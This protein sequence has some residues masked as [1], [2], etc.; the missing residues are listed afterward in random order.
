MDDDVECQIE[1]REIISDEGHESVV[2]DSLDV[3][4]SQVIQEFLSPN[5]FQGASSS[6]VPFFTLNGS[7]YFI[8]EVQE[9]DKPVV[10]TVF[11][12][13]DEAL[14]MYQ[15]YAQKARFSVRKY[16]AKRKSN[17]DLSHRL[18]VCNR[19]GKHKKKINVD[20]T[21]RYVQVKNNQQQSSNIVQHKTHNHVL[22]LPQDKHLA[23]AQRQLEFE[24]RHFIQTVRMNNIGP[25]KAYRLRACLN[26]GYD[27]V[28]GTA[29]DYKNH[30]RDVNVC[31]GERDAQMLI[32]RFSKR[33][34]NNLEFFF[35]YKIEQ[36]ELVGLFWA[37]ET[38]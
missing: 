15:S 17:G 20:T 28:R 7:R 3:E 18:F 13:L 33:K 5:R 29:V 22:D 30:Q 19:Q 9:F 37:D 25:V 34:L 16:T 36:D 31:I 6:S 4:P 38:S 14:V 8:P 1:S 23:K 10:G 21:Q 24:D 11:N 12:S 27:Q 26:G 35:H 2:F 32:D